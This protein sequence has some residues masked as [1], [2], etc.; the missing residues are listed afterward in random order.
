MVWIILSI[1]F[2]YMIAIKTKTKLV[3]TILCLP[4]AILAAIISA[5][6]LY[7]SEVR[8]A[9]ETF[10]A[11]ITNSVY[12]FILSLIVMFYA[13]HKLKKEEDEFQS[14][15]LTGKNG[16]T[17]G[18]DFGDFS[19]FLDGKPSK[20]KIQEYASALISAGANKE[21]I[22]SI[23]KEKLGDKYIDNINP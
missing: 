12:G 13:K 17:L 3:G 5:T 14:N 11:I 18:F 15:N 7:L 19:Q 22:L 8:N 9:G 23:L 10:I 1:L 4:S 16:R 2:A 21:D 6:F 20:E